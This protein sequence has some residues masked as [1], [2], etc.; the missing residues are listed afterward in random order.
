MGDGQGVMRRGMPLYN[1][2]NFTP[3]WDRS[4]AFVY[5]LIDILV[6]H[7]CCEVGMQQ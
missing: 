1:R 2:E 3:F 5:L 4:G 6:E 7:L